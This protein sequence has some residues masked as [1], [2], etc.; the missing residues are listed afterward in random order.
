M[1]EF[2]QA[3]EARRK[4]LMHRHCA[5]HGDRIG[6]ERNYCRACDGEGGDGFNQ[7]TCTLDHRTE[8]ERVEAALAA[9][10]DLVGDSDEGAWLKTVYR[11]IALQHADAAQRQQE[12][13]TPYERWQ[14]TGEK[15]VA[16]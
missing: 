1:T 14:R 7:R 6:P 12:A 16:L 9:L 5:I 2:E 8:A 4:A 11:H 3:V 10:V 15:D 13:E